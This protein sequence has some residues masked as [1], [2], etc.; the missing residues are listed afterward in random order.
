MPV[1]M[2]GSCFAVLAMSVV[3]EG[4]KAARHWLRYAAVRHSRNVQDNSGSE[5]PV[6]DAQLIIS[7]PVWLT[8]LVC[9]D[10][11]QLHLHLCIITQY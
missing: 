5:T 6:D 8:G 10:F 4:L 3:Y 1:G 11:V 9:T 2:L 7:S